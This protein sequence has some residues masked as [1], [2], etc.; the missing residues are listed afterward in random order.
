[1]A[2]YFYRDKSGL[3]EDSKLLADAKV[4]AFDVE[5]TGPHVG[6]DLPVGFSLAYSPDSAYYGH[7]EDPYLRPIL[8]DPSRLK[9]AHN[10][11]FD[12]SMAKKAGI[13]IDNLCCTMIAAH[14][15]ERT[16]LSLKMLSLLDLGLDVISYSDVRRRMLDMTGDELLRYSGPHSRAT[17]MLWG[18]YRS[19]LSA[20]GLL[21][22]FWNIEMPLVPVI[23]DMELNGVMVDPAVLNE[24]DIEF[25][26]KIASL[27]EALNYWSNTS[28]V[29]FNS[30]DQVAD[31]FYDKDKM[32]ITPPWQ[33]TSG[34]RPSVNVTHLKEV[35]NKHPILP[36]YYMFKSYMTLKNS[37]LKSLAKQIQADGRV[38]GSFNQTNTRTSRLSSSDPNLQKIPVRTA[39]GKRIREAFVA[40]EG[41]VL[42]KSDYDQLEL[43]ALAIC[44]GDKGLL[45]AFKAG[46]D[47]HV[48]TAVRV[49]QDE[50]RRREGK[51]LNYQ[52]TFG[53]GSIARRNMFFSAYPR[54]KEWI[55]ETT[56]EVRRVAMVKTLGGRRR[57]IH[58]HEIL[59]IGPRHEKMLSHGDREAISTIVQGSSAEIVKMGMRRIWEKTRDTDVKMLLQVHDELV[60]EVPEAILMDVAKVVKEEMT[61]NDY[62]IPLTVSLEVGKNWGD[63]KKLAV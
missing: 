63:M 57:T 34:G 55:D 23:S 26:A 52:L 2:S 38:Y 59:G 44:S 20:L 46:R 40:P 10:A 53:G 32:G 58:A 42:L 21:N 49:F 36:I 4:L 47:I 37:Y 13:T 17:L 19:K 41:K 1:M 60:F 11:S 5:S 3:P 16:E 25:S 18:V 7:I 61:C 28:G 54:V 33:K 15:L 29:N 45:A 62:E 6:T 56:V 48:E 22:A 9:V 51:T 50:T 24:L 30:P 31:L 43:V 39:D 14:L 12:R 27:N 35:E 8:A